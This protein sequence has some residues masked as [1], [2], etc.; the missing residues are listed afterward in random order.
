MTFTV[1]QLRAIEKAIG[2]D[3]EVKVGVEY[4][5]HRYDSVS[6][7]EATAFHEGQQVRARESLSH[8]YSVPAHVIAEKLIMNI[9]HYIMDMELRRAF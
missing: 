6:Y 3:A 8:L 2:R 4:S 9:N 1:K 5:H 7:I